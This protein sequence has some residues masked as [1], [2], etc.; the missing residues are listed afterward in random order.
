MVT[1]EEAFYY[2]RYVLKNTEE[3]DDYDRMEPQINDQYPRRG[4]LWNN[5]GIVLG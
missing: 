2:A 4:I 1:V 5:K 3:L